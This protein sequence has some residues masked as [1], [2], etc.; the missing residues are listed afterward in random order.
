MRGTLTCYTS[1]EVEA[2]TTETPSTAHCQHQAQLA[3]SCQDAHRCQLTERHGGPACL[4]STAARHVRTTGAKRSY[5]LHNHMNMCAIAYAVYCYSSMQPSIIAW[6]CCHS[7]GHARMS[8]SSTRHMLRS[9]RMLSSMLD[10]MQTARRQSKQVPLHSLQAT[11]TQTTRAPNQQA[12]LHHISCHAL[13]TCHA[14]T[15]CKQKNLKETF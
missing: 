12:L 6:A 13:H 2:A 10:C 15:Q 5:L 1:C 4:E 11:T 9:M 3:K 7:I 14:C 8:V